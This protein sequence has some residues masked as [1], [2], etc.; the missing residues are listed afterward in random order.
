MTDKNFV[1]DVAIIGFTQVLMSLG[2]FLLLPII[3]KTLGSYD[4]GTW[5]Q[6]S[7]TLSLLS[8]VALMGLSMGAV[9]F[10]SS[11][12]E[13]TKIRE[14]FF[15]IIIFVIFTGFIV[16]M[17]VFLLADLLAA[18]I[19]KDPHTTYFIKAGSFLI[20]LAAIDQITIFYFRIFRYIQIFSYLNLFQVFGKL[21]LIFIFLKMGF[22]LL[23]VISAILIIQILLFIIAMSI[24]I[25]Q[26]GFAIPRFSH[27]SEYLKYS[28]PL[29]PNSLIRWITDFSDRYVVGYFL[30]LS[31]VG[32][33]SASYAIG[34][35][36]S[37]F[38]APIQMI[39]FP[40][41]SKLFDN[42]DIDKVQAYLSSSMKY[43]LLIAIPAVFGLSALSKPILNI[44]TTSEFASGSIVIP[45]IALSGLL[46]GIFQIVINIT[47]LVKKT[48]FNLYIHVVAAL[49][50][51]VFNFI[52]I[53]SIGILGAA[54]AT[55]ISY[56]VMVLACIHISFKHITFDWNFI[57]ISKC[58]VASSIMYGVILLKSP[59]NATELLILSGLGAV[60]YLLILLSFKSFSKNEIKAVK[61]FYFTMKS[62]IF[63]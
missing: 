1:K 61:N 31:S 25:S 20:L 36:V 26:I 47:H 56:I 53:P 43:F 39:L 3:T 58:I 33:Y 55:L 14:G 23:G 41:L 32:I 11:E 40:E 54:I 16:S 38:V 49:L 18:T 30:G 27:I 28:A 21:F 60:I 4:Y 62:N 10:L 59:S 12:T 42:G 50:N 51:I 57:F 44:L 48:K 29:T 37:L 13:K 22:G 7:I 2:G 6:I 46:A 17:L 8:T 63:S 15:S 34:N 5:S 19:F 45:I 52:L 35:L 24:V 9:R